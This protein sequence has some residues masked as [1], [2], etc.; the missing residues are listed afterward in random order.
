MH[1][2]LVCWCN[3]KIIR[4]Q[5]NINLNENGEKNWLSGNRF[6]KCDLHF[7]KNYSGN[8]KSYDIAVELFT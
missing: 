3:V 4:K 7:V 6:L 5:V 2:A 1:S 8:R